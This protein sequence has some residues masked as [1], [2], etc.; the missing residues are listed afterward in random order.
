MIPK[1]SNTVIFLTT[2][3]EIWEAVKITYSKVNDASQIYEIR[4]KI[5]TTKQGTQSIT[6]YA[7]LL[8]TFWQELDHYQCIQMKC[9]GD[10]A[11]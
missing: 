3:K 5:A 6:E 8:Q 7:N 4:T 2:G 9:S 1:I 11:I 10:V